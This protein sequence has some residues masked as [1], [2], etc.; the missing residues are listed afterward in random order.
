MYQLKY[1]QMKIIK[2]LLL[3]VVAV[4][5]LQLG[6]AQENKITHSPHEV[7][8]FSYQ[9]IGEFCL[10]QT[11]VVFDITSPYSD[12]NEIFSTLYRTGFN[13]IN[14]VVYKEKISIGLGIGIDCNPL[15]EL[16]FPIFA[17]FRYYFTEKKLQPFIN[18]GVGA[19]PAIHYG[20][21]NRKYYN[22]GLYINF[23]S[24][25]KYNHFQ[26]NTG[27]NMKTYKYS[28]VKYLTLELFIKLGFNY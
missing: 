19:M 12:K 11:G 2:L 18:I 15:G 25:F 26:F 28:S 1:K 13:L 27:I 16:G 3:I 24:G 8:K 5:F 21:F 14:S 23:S 9:L 6:F 4:F 17:D 20:F 22:P 7:K 10:V